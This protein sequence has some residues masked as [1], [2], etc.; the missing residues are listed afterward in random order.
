MKN[1]AIITAVLFAGLTGI[2]Q[3]ATIIL[4]DTFTTANVNGS[5]P[6]WTK[7]GA[8]LFGG[9]GV[10]TNTNYPT[11]SG[12]WAYFQTNGADNSG[13]FRSTGTVGLDAQVIIFNFDLGGNNSANLYT[14]SFTASI[15]DGSPTG[16][17]T[18]LAT[19]NPTNPAGGVRSPITLSHT[20]AADT[21]NNIFVQF[22][23]TNTSA[24]NGGNGN[25]NQAIVDNVLVTI[26][27]PSTAFLGALGALCLLRRRR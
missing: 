27:E 19:I 17:G 13:M 21:T 20:L 9:I 1:K 12:S 24:G 25:F 7:T 22:N 14:G 18:Q 16:G 5:V 2:G 8:N 26:P 23:A 4:N 10:E 11:G 3:S 6:G 15:W